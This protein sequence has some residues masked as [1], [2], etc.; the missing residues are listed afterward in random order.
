MQCT[1]E[2]YSSREHEPNSKSR[3]HT[4]RLVSHSSTEQ[5]GKTSRT[6]GLPALQCRV[7]AAQKP[8]TGGKDTY[9]QPTR[10]SDQ[11]QMHL[12]QIFLN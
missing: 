12:K 5:P 10:R 2:I 6:L 3:K 9:L 7:P 4:P 11:K 1:R 8:L